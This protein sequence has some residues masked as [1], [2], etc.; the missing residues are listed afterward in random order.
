[1]AYTRKPRPSKHYTGVLNEPILL[2]PA[3]APSRIRAEVMAEMLIEERLPL[4]FAHYGIDPSRPGAERL[5]IRALAQKHV[6]GFQMR[7]EP[8]GQPSKWK[9]KE[10]TW[11]LFADVQVLIQKGHSER[12]ACHLLTRRAMYRDQEPESLRRRY[13]EADANGPVPGA[14]SRRGPGFRDLIVA[15]FRSDSEFDPHADVRDLLRAFSSD[16]EATPK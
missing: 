10:K 9:F 15:L 8:R 16:S 3:E 1:M 5:L 4:L 14:L 7:K 2:P 6:P 11:R 12:Q 13:R